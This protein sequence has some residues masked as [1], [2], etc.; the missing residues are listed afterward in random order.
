M[1]EELISCGNFVEWINDANDV[2]CVEYDAGGNAKAS[3]DDDVTNC[4]A[5]DDADEAPIAANFVAIIVV[6]DALAHVVAAP[7]AINVIVAHVT[8]TYA[9]CTVYALMLLLISMLL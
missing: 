4:S 5:D 7:I 6:D 9:A 1:I 3:T 2:A 8:A